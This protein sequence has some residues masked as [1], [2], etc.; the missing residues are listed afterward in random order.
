VLLDGDLQ[1]PP[2]LI[3]QFV[4]EWRK[5]FDVVYGR[6]VKRDATL[7]MQFAY[8]AFYRVFDYFSYVP[9]PHDA[10]DFSLLDRKVVNAL[11]Q[12]PERDLFLRGLRAFAGFR[13]TGVD[14]H[15]PE[16]MFGRST[17]NLMR[18]FGWAKKGILS[19]SNT[20]LNILSV[21]GLVLLMCTVLLALVQVILRVFRP[22]SVPQGL[23]TVLLAIMFFGSLSILSTAIVG[24]YIAKIFEEVKRRPLFIR[25]SVVRNGQI[26][27]VVSE[28]QS[29]MTDGRT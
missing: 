21:A 7:F 29:E 1:D 17:N 9:V 27:Q 15:R 6:R 5:G 8:K 23:T 11:T 28:S 18:N 19:F 22:D 4:G 10:G 13:Q 26:R 16:R 20:P 14:Y 12:F 25:R 3:E 24:E 2:E